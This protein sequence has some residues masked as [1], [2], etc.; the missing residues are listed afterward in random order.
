MA[1]AVTADEVMGHLTDEDHPAGKDPL[2]ADAQRRGAGAEVLKAIR[3]VP[4][5]DY[6]SRDEVVRSLRLDPAPHQEPGQQA[7]A[8]PPGVSQASRA[9]QE[10]RVAEAQRCGG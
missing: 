2:L 8:A 4:P 7:R 6:R 3:A 9:P 10:D 5:V 1:D